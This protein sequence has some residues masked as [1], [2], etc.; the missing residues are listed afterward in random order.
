MQ[1]IT[2]IVFGLLITIILFSIF[3][4]DA[5]LSIFA[6]I[7]AV[8]PDIDFTESIRHWHRKLLHNIWTIGIATI[9]VSILFTI[10]IGIAF[11]LG[12]LSHLIADSLTPRGIY[13]LWPREK[14][15]LCYHTKF[16]ISTGRISEKIFAIVIFILSIF[17]FLLQSFKNMN[18]LIG[19]AVATIVLFFVFSKYLPKVY[20]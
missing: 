18:E 6:G 13:P 19:I 5:G 3:H 4:L 9:I 2:H 17:I 1:R 11:I 15:F 12:A 14:P 16:K 8:F 7:G 20:R 10:L